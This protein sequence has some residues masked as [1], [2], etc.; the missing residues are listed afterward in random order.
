M[1]LHSSPDSGSQSTNFLFFLPITFLDL[2]LYLEVPDNL[3]IFD[4]HCR[5]YAFGISDALAHFYVFTD[6]RKGFV[7]LASF[8]S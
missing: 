4:H 1:H 7:D 3:Y 5:G 2:H 6:N 8:F